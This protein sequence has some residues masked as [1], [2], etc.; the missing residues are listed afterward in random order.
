MGSQILKSLWVV[1]ELGYVHCD[2]KLANIC[3]KDH[4]QDAEKVKPFMYK[5]LSFKESSTFYLIDFG[6]SRNYNLNK[7]PR[8]IDYF[9]GNLMFAS[10]N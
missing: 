9:V 3:I 8:K 5:P 10:G 4:L 1:H 6:L 7:I 2:L